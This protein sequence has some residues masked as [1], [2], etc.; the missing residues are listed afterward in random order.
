MKKL[1]ALVLAGIVLAALLA[2]AGGATNIDTG[3]EADTAMLDENPGVTTAVDFDVQP[4]ARAD[5][6]TAEVNDEG[7]T[8]LICPPADLRAQ[9]DVANYVN[10]ESCS[11]A[12]SSLSADNT[13]YN[14]KGT[15]LLWRHEQAGPLHRWLR[16]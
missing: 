5:V 3:T 12:R 15:L 7:F 10:D 4:A 8:V 1:T 14:G 9:N 11:S 13:F 6:A 16:G 2:F